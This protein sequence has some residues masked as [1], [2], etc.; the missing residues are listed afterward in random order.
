MIEVLYKK[1]VI[2]DFLSLFTENYWK[3]LIGY[4][5]EYGII[6]FKKHH[7]IN[8]MSPEDITQI[9]DKMKRDENLEEKKMTN[10]LKSRSIS[11]D[12]S[13]ITKSN[14][15][16]NFGTAKAIAPITKVPQ[17]SI[18]PQRSNLN[19]KL[20]NNKNNSSSDS[21]HNK[22]KAKKPILT[23]PNNE[24]DNDSRIKSTRN[25]NK[26]STNLRPNNSKPQKVGIMEQ[27]NLNKLKERRNKSLIRSKTATDD[28]SSK[29][30]KLLYPN[31]ESRIKKDVEKD[32]KIYKNNNSVA[33][34]PVA[35][36]NNVVN[37][38]SSS[39]DDGNIVMGNK[40]P[41][42]RNKEFDENKHIKNSTYTNYV[43]QKMNNNNNTSLTSTNNTGTVGSN[44]LMMTNNMYSNNSNFNYT[45]NYNN[46]N[47]NRFI[48]D[49]TPNFEDRLNGF[50]QRV[51]A[52]DENHM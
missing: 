20:K 7:N 35:K 19:N 45:S 12:K 38:H 14:S 40:Q 23:R 30:N 36:K 17:R 3:Q 33:Y 44:N 4:L 42:I 48:G 52:F 29:K 47:N 39:S 10:L 1:K 43:P 27:V 8:S 28:E 31:V 25:N 46:D 5:L 21:K 26:S 51:S 24:S 41:L 16:A 18:T 13:V 22:H 9:I 34:H 50:K 37:N 15:K 2:R 49:K 32:K 11:K 6:V